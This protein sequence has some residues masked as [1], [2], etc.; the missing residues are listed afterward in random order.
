MH[1]SNDEEEY[2][3]CS[4]VSV[5]I[6]AYNEED[7]IGSTIEHVLQVL[8]QTLPGR[9]YE[10]IVVD[11]GSTDKSADI[12]RTFE[13]VKLI[14]RP[15][16]TGYG[17]AIKAG[18]KSARY[19]WILTVDA[20][21]QHRLNDLCSFLEARREGYDLIIGSRGKKSHMALIRR[22]G[23]AVMG[24]IAN[25]LANTKIPDV[26]SGLR[27]FKKSVFLEFMPLYPQR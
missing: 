12:A 2:S 16:N 17:T 15:Y 23:K 11:D 5:I 6:P 1:F 19:E 10:V 27:L 14:R 9:H 4:A 7:E 8:S 25:Y 13:D 21:G 20:D 24:I 18:I 26:N 22:P 3:G